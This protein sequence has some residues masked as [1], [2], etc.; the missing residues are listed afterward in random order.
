MVIQ[1]ILSTP[2][3]ELL[4][5]INQS[6]S[7]NLTYFYYKLIDRDNETITYTA[8]LGRPLSQILTFLYFSSFIFKENQ[9]FNER[10]NPSQNF[11]IVEEKVNDIDMDDIG[12]FRADH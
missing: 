2:I 6:N 7:G 4:V 5:W 12:N 10:D 9:V 8:K 1:S 3:K 11:V